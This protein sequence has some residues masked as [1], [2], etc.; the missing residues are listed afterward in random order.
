MKFLFDDPAFDYQALRTAGY[1]DFGGA[2]LGEVMA[3]T[4]RVPEG[5]TDSWCR[6][7][8]ALAERVA[9]L[10]YNAL[11]EDRTADARA[12][13][14]RAHNY[15]RT[16]EFFLRDDPGRDAAAVRLFKA[17]KDVF[18]QA[19]VLLERPPEPVRIPYENT[20]LPGHFYRADDS[21]VPRP[22]IIHHGGIDST[23]EE[24][25]FFIAAAAMARGY[26]CLCFEGP[27]QGSVLRDQGLTFRPDWE[28]VVG[29]AVDYALTLPGVD[30]SRLAL[31]GTS[32]GGLLCLRAAAFEHRLAGCVAHDAVWQLGDVVALPPFVL[33]WVEQGCDDFAN[34]VMYGIA[35]QQTF[36]R[37]LLRQ[38]MWTF[39]ADT[40]AELL[41]RL[42]A[43]G[44]SEVLGAVDCPVLVLDAEEDMFFAG[45]EHA[46]KV[47]AALNSPKTLHVFT[48]EEGGGAH[49]HSGA[50]HLYH[51]RL[52][53][54]L[55]QTLGPLRTGAA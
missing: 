4:S 32:L 45:L 9:R 46:K 42:P 39:G 13:L 27:G 1:A 10:G 35:A 26:H 25:Y 49:C 19:A 15:Y 7:W 6:E 51:D 5:D 18:S 38:A 24:G 36:T 28:E 54:W 2:Q 55:S 21:G 14:L 12:S 47:Y 16:A 41:R 34:P 11:D 48:R 43:F 17:S 20:S 40:P 8:S 52:F 50:M 31:V 37:W 44:L 30:A 23:L 29:P 22:T 33:E 3:V 53:S